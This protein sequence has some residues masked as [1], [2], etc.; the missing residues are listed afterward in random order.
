MRRKHLWLLAL[1]CVMT[2][3]AAIAQSASERSV[4]DDIITG[5]SDYC[6]RGL[7]HCVT[8]IY[9]DGSPPQSCNGVYN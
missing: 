7:M 1:A 3:T 2:G 5:C 9:G 4:S 8:I 6:S